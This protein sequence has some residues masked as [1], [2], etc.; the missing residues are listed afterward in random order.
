MGLMSMKAG[1][2]RLVRKHGPELAT[3]AKV[4]TSVLI[5]GGGVL[6]EALGHMCDHVARHG[7]RDDAGLTEMIAQLGDDQD[8]VLKLLSCPQIVPS[9]RPACLRCAT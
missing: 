3:C 7:D 1:L 9:F 6:A 8:H 5:P 4:A 2:A